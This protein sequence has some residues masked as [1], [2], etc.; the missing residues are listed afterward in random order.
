MFTSES[1]IIVEQGAKLTI[2]GAKL[3]TCPLSPSWKGLKVP[4]DYP[5]AWGFGPPSTEVI[6]RGEGIIEHAEVAIDAVGQLT[7]LSTLNMG[8]AKI[9][10]EN[11]SAISHCGIGVKLGPLYG[12][13]DLSSFDNSFFNLI[14]RFFKRLSAIST[15]NRR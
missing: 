13:N 8:G 9:T 14:T 7:F 4:A 12:V 5:A 1:Q 11:G 6:V 10:I 3:T 2:E 15:T